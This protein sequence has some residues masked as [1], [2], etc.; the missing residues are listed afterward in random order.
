LIE[1][2]TASLRRIKTI[3]LALAIAAA[4]VGIAAC[5]DDD[6]SQ[7]SGKNEQR[8]VALDLTIGDL[9][10]LS[11]ELADFGPPGEKA[12][13]IA[14]D[15]INDAIDEVGA[16]HTVKLKTADDET[17]DH[18]GVV[19]A[20]K[21]VADGAGCIAGS[22]A[23]SV[24]ITVAR[25]VSIPD[26]VLQISPASTTDELTAL[27]DD[28]LVNRTVPPDSAQGPALAEAI[29]D[30]LGGAKDKTVNVGA[31]D[32]P[33]GNAI[34]TAF[35]DAWTARGGKIGKEVIYDPDSGSFD[36][37]AE[38][39][40][41]GDPDATV[42]ADFAQT[43]E[44]L[45]PALVSI[46]DYDPSTTWG[47]DGLASASLPNALGANVI[48]RL[49]GTTPG[50]PDDESTRAFDELFDST[51]PKDVDRHP[52][53][54]QNFDAVV[55]CY[56]AAVAAGSTDGLE[57]AGV[58]QEVSAPPGHP[59]TWTQLADAI[60]ALEHGKEIDYQG[61]SGPI[62][63][64]ESGDATAGVYDIYEY[65]GHHLELAEELP[66]KAPGSSG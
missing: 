43:F 34:A 53:D 58:V 2:T 41:A 4:V 7:R 36:G 48:Q 25:S 26:G 56:L 19:A 65:R 60:K 27:E 28:G 44:K 23:P 8:K 39:I 5:N 16:D 64:N 31:R 38:K 57:M 30:D 14:I 3:L 10:P 15:R 51:D 6:S 9:V 21:L 37:E 35:E 42:I 50:T 61:A 59:Y 17:S 29:A 33:Y 54:A 62:D 47:T 63:M 52:F 18:A 32:D 20:R 12:A 24:T 40:T 49:R 46:G 13:E 11:G 55:L 45:G 1:N 66:I 22:W